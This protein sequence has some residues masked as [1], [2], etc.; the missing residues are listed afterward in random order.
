MLPW[1]YLYV[2][3]RLLSWHFI[4]FVPWCKLFS[5]VYCLLLLVLPYGLPHQ[6]YIAILHL[7]FYPT[8]G[9]TFSF[10]VYS[11][12]SGDFIN[13]LF[14]I[15]LDFQLSSSKCYNKLEFTS[16]YSVQ[17]L[18]TEVNARLAIGLS[19]YIIFSVQRTRR[20]THT[21]TQYFNCSFRL[22]FVFLSVELMREILLRT[23]D[24]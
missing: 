13:D 15:I 2:G 12:Q 24:S 16:N 8:I 10:I 9:E 14:F 5:C 1:S 7:L 17:W 3:L 4:W 6:F 21:H 19:S 23:W 18:L 22:F 11:I 20:C